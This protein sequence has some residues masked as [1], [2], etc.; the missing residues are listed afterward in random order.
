MIKTQT[1]F[2]LGAGASVPFGYPTGGKLRDDICSHENVHQLTELLRQDPHGRFVHYD[3][4][5]TVGRFTDEFKESKSYS[6]DAFLESRQE[7]MKIGKMAIA[8]ILKNYEI[9]SE[10]SKQEGNWYM[11]LF[12]RMKDCDFKDFN[13]NKIS[14]VTFNYDLS[15]EQFLS[16]ALQF[17]YGKNPSQV[18]EVLREIPI[19]HLYGKI[20]SDSYATDSNFSSAIFNAD[21]N[22][23]L[24]KDERTD[25]NGADEITEEFQMAHNLISTAKNIYFLGFG[26][27][28]INLER[29]NIGLM[30]AKTIKFTS[31]GVEPSIMS[32]I[33]RQFGEAI[34]VAKPCDCIEMLQA[35]LAFE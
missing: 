26:F 7:Y 11:Y 12:N 34:L 32:W 2:I 31:K 35:Y 21:K 16:N 9:K 5:G 29:L 24:I 4:N 10:L 14:F 30:Q 25:N 20:N 13:K 19:V 6:I 1:L 18:S 17:F 23:K 33:Q 15:L 3:L 27:D 28:K 8:L 22:L